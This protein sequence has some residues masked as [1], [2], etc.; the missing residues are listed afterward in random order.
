MIQVPT[1]MFLT[2]GV[3]RDAE[4]LI[5]FEKA[6]RDAGIAPFN[7]V[8]VSSI[9]PPGAVLV[10]KDEGLKLLEKCHGSVVF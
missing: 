6:L 4:K 3:G 8:S 2:N 10:S 5:S 9:F 7:L 1:K